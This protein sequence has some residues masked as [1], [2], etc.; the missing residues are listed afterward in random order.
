MVLD[1]EKITVSCVNIKNP[2]AVSIMDEDVDNFELRKIGPL[3]ENNPAFSNRIILRLLI[4]FQKM[5]LRPE[6]LKEG[7]V[8]L[9]LQEQVLQHV[10]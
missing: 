4:S 3:V 8:K 7:Q 6:Y 1:L 9:Y 10:R 5:K 2:H